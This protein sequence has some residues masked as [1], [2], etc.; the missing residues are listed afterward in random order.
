MYHTYITKYGTI[1]KDEMDNF[2]LYS[3]IVFQTCFPFRGF[4]SFRTIKQSQTFRLKE[5]IRI[6]D[7]TENLNKTNLTFYIELKE[8][9]L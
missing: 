3:E 7:L 4:L 8:F 6:Y 2:C 1:V 5:E 9:C